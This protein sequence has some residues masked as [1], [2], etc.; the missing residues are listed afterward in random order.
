MAS[1]STSAVSLTWANCSSISPILPGALMAF[2]PRATTSLFRVSD[3]RLSTTARRARHNHSGTDQ[4]PNLNDQY[5]IPKTSSLMPGHW[6]F[7]P[8]C[9]S[10]RRCKQLKRPL[11]HGAGHNSFGGVQAVF[12]FGEDDRLRAIDHGVGHF[13]AAVGW[14]AMHVHG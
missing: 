4:W 1:Q 8:S 12:G 13:R 10:C 2:P 9:S 3:M 11:A 14:K 5:F 7:R 6:S